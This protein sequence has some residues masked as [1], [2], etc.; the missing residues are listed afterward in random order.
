MV[1]AF[2]LLLACLDFVLRHARPS[3]RPTPQPQPEGTTEEK[4][5]GTQPSAAA[6]TST[7]TRL[8][9]SGSSTSGGGGGSG[10]GRK[11][12]GGVGALALGMGSLEEDAI[13]ALFMMGGVRVFVFGGGGGFGGWG[14]RGLFVSRRVNARHRRT[15]YLS[16]SMQ[17]YIQG[18]PSP[19]A[20]PR[21]QTSLT[22]A[23]ASL[24]PAA[25]TGVLCMCLRATGWINVGTEPRAHRN[26]HTIR[27]TYT[28]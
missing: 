25:R 18:P 11:G 15:A 14:F 19:T 6:S 20:V 4:E 24:G 22:A 5:L 13:A 26:K 8:R 27:C 9:S 2:H 3:P 7:S 17:T 1:A 16:T 12:V 10:K 23:A 21:T 28:H